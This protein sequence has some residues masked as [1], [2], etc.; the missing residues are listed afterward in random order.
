MFNVAATD[1]DAE[2]KSL[3]LLNFQRFYP[4]LAHRLQRWDRGTFGP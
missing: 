4:N 3:F 2:V 1:E